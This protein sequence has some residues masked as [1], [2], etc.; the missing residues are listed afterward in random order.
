M[1][2][3]NIIKIF[4]LFLLLIGPSTKAQTSNV[5]PILT[6]TGNQI[7][8][9]G[10]SMKIVTNMTIVDPDDPGVT[11][12]YIQISSGYV[13]GQDVLTL[14]GS[15]PTIN[16]SWDSNT[17]KLTL[18]GLFG[19]PTYT[20]LEAAI[21]DIEYSNSSS[22]P[23]GI[24]TFSI[25]IGQANYLPSNGHYYQYIP[26]IGIT[27][28]DARL[29][30]TTNFYYGIQ[31]YLATITA[32]DEAQIAGEQSEGAGW[33][34]GSD[35]QQEGVWRWMTGPE[36]GTLFTYTLWNTGEPNSAGD[37]DYTH[38]TAPGV[39]IPGSWNDISNTGATSGFYQPKGYI[40]EYGGMP[41]DP[42]IQIST[43]TTIT[44]PSIV[45]TTPIEICNP[46]V[47][48][49]GATANVPVI[50][51]YTS[52]TGGTPIATGTTFTT[53]FLNS[54]TTFFADASPFG[55]NSNIRTAV[56]ASVNTTPILT[57][58]TNVSI[59][60]N[61]PTILNASTTS[62]VINWYS[63][64]TST[65][66]L[67][68]GTSFTTPALTQNTNYYIEG[69]NNGCLSIGRIA[70]NVQIITKPIVV[71]ENLTLCENETLTL[72]AGIN[73]VSYLWSTSETTNTIT[74]ASPGIY[75]VLITDLTPQGCSNTKTF[76]IN[77]NDLPV[78]DDVLINGTTATII[79]STFGDYEYSIDGVSFQTSNV[80][81]VSEGGFYTALVRGKNN[82]GF[83]FKEFA[84]ITIPSFFTPNGDGFNDNWTIKGL[85]Y[86]TNAKVS[87]F[88]RYGKLIKQLNAIDNNWDGTLN[89]Q[90]L[91]SDDYWFTFKKDENTPEIKGHFSLK[92]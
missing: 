18:I 35:E 36:T 42:I 11:A 45:S 55:C 83:D 32:A 8:C 27:W 86:Y 33:I 69:N 68:T 20:E 34:G 67:V 64:L 7:Y 66:P 81:T 19:Q 46:G 80:F 48:T 14:T 92:R 38:I 88:N 85:M 26:N 59:C 39:G 16:S 10:T 82:C 78:I 65:T 57:T 24:R 49:L 77:Q 76:T 15:H 25:S 44:I 72:N 74:I 9:P 52:A 30:A 21:E 73:N 90:L 79:V 75:S 43:S 29:A 12:I 3:K 47:L 50:N 63:S 6:A 87:I 31:G 22:N 71:D 28:S 58:N 5:A 89:N 1:K 51:W 56:T 17:G 41:G 62:G 60:E 4:I 23:S 91:P 84:V 40:V 37:E 61:T 2:I 53:P 54:T 70:I 13:S